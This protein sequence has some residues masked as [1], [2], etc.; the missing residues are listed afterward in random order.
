[1]STKALG[2]IFGGTAKS[3]DPKRLWDAR[4]ACPTALDDIADLYGC[5]I[6]SKADASAAD[7]GTLPIASLLAKVAEAESPDSPGGVAKT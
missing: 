4:A 6:V 2:N 5:A 7:L 3:T 1:L